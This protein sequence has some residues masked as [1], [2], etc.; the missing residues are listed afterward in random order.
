MLCVDYGSL[1]ALTIKDKFPIRTVDELLGEL[2][3]DS[4]FLDLT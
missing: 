3:G 4:V 2:K 1:N